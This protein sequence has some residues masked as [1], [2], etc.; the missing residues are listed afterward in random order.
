VGILDRFHKK[1]GGRDARKDNH[2]AALVARVEG[3]DKK[4]SVRAAT[5]LGQI[6]REDAAPLG[7]AILEVYLTSVG[8]VGTWSSNESVINF[9]K[10]YNDL[11]A[12]YAN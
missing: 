5:D 6:V 11:L 3:P 7:D 12:R 4:N 9:V 10:K 1:S 2:I 8:S